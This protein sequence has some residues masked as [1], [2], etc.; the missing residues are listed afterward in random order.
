MTRRRRSWL[1][2]HGWSIGPRR[3]RKLR[4]RGTISK[5]G[6]LTLSVFRGKRAGRGAASPESTSLQSL[7]GGGEPNFRECVRY[8]DNRRKGSLVAEGNYHRGERALSARIDRARARRFSSRS[9]RIWDISVSPISCR[10]RSESD[11]GFDEATISPG[12]PREIKY[13]SA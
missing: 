13:L 2:R 4:A 5:A 8:L 7:R 3:P 1:S 9:E 11:P 12:H 10:S 6:P